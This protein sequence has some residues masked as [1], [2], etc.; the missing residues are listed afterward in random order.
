M[1]AYSSVFQI[2]HENGVEVCPEFV[3]LELGMDEKN[4][5]LI[6]SLRA[7]LNFLTSEI[8]ITT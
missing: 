6:Q 3:V 2:I 4:W 1:L 5:Y 7:K 8:F